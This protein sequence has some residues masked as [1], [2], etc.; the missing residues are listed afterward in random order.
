MSS[1]PEA[2]ECDCES[3]CKRDGKQ[4]VRRSENYYN[5]RS[6]PAELN[7]RRMFEKNTLIEKVKT[8]VLYSCTTEDEIKAFKRLVDAAIESTLGR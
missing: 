5:R 3:C 8:H 4:Y 7:H 2:V 1:S 6:L